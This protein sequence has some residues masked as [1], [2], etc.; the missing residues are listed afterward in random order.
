MAV[1][2]KAVSI[3]KDRK[4]FVGF[5]RCFSVQYVLKF[6]VLSGKVEYDTKHFAA[7]FSRLGKNRFVN[8][9]LY[10]KV[11]SYNFRQFGQNCYLIK[12]SNSENVIHF[13][14]QLYIITELSI[15]F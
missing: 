12:Y 7:R 13:C 2:N 8:A 4:N 6:H 1:H 14:A 9:F 5:D 10:K 15:F 11:W 3:F